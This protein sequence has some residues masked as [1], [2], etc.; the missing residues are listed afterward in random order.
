MENECITVYAPD[1]LVIALAIEKT[2]KEVTEAVRAAVRYQLG[3]DKASPAEI[4]KL[5]SAIAIDWPSTRSVKSRAMAGSGSYQYEISLQPDMEADPRR[6]IARKVAKELQGKITISAEFHNDRRAG[7]QLRARLRQLVEKKIMDAPGSRPPDATAIDPIVDLIE[8]NNVGSATGHNEAKF[9]YTLQVRPDWEFD[10]PAVQFSDE[11][12]VDREIAGAVVAQWGGEFEAG[13]REVAKASS[14]EQ[15]YRDLDLA[16]VATVKKIAAE[17]SPRIALEREK[18]YKVLSFI[19]SQVGIRKVGSADEVFFKLSLAPARESARSEARTDREILDAAAFLVDRGASLGDGT[20]SSIMKKLESKVKMHFA[21]LLDKDEDVRRVMEL[22]ELYWV[23]G[24]GGFYDIR[25]KSAAHMANWM[26]VN[27]HVWQESSFKGTEDAKKLAERWGREQIQDR[28]GPSYRNVAISTILSEITVKAGEPTSI[29]RVPNSTE[30]LYTIPLSFSVKTEQ[31]EAVKREP[32]KKEKALATEIAMLESKRAAFQHL[33]DKGVGEP[34]KSTLLAQ[35]PVLEKTILEKTEELKALQARPEGPRITLAG[36]L[37][38]TASSRSEARTDREILDLAID[39][40]SRGY[41][42]EDANQLE[43]L[44][45]FVMNAELARSEGVPEPEVGRPTPE[46]DHDI[47]RVMEL[48]EIYKIKDTKD[49]YLRLTMAARLA[50]FMN[51]NHSSWGRVFENEE[52]RDSR[53]EAAAQREAEAFGRAKLM[54][55]S[56]GV[57]ESTRAR[58]TVTAGDM[59]PSD[60]VVFYCQL[61]YAVKPG[62]AEAV[63]ASADEDTL[64]A[65]IAGLESKRAAFQKMLDKKGIVDSVRRTL[66]SQIPVLEEAIRTKKEALAALQAQAKK[67]GKSYRQIAEKVVNALPGQTI[68]VTYI[69]QPSAVSPA[70]AHKVALESLELQV[71]AELNKGN[72]DTPVRLKPE[73]MAKYM[74][75]IHVPSNPLKARRE[76]DGSSLFE[77]QVMLAPAA[78]RSEARTDGEKLISRVDLSHPWLRGSTAEVRVTLA[79]VFQRS[80]IR[81][82]VRGEVAPENIPAIEG[83]ARSVGNLYSVPGV[84]IFMD[85]AKRSEARLWVAAALMMEQNPLPEAKIQAGWKALKAPQGI[86]NADVL[87]MGRKLFLADER[88][89]VAVSR[90]SGGATIAV[91]VKGREE[92]RLLKELNERLVAAGLK[93]ILAADMLRKRLPTLGSSRVM[94]LLYQGETLPEELSQLIADENVIRVDKAM[95]GKFLREVGDFVKDLVSDLAGRFA[96]ARSA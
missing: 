51:K 27:S 92:R 52:R 62:R 28:F 55:L 19:R 85:P 86:E 35:I 61:S 17:R 66:V 12:R 77:F 15:A 16:L 32:G 18:I 63:K 4:D 54:E 13:T 91:V 75:W 11:I 49:Y 9:H 79:K 64:A 40:S 89:A 5:M 20:E 25:L 50:D 30:Y 94:A 81:D 88:A 24:G 26:N 84:G 80:E 7:D 3:G 2:R 74:S 70:E 21:L 6:T 58:I 33:L 39:F 14:L 41:S 53:W 48:L 8:A 65:E 56:S 90:S 38:E 76:T 31:S 43:E 68:T 73:E 23:A 93:P 67:I 71:I 82:L 10:L 60:D 47:H 34:V 78:N 83:A 57:D 69:P 29:V 72:P 87:L 22:L 59:H 95:L 1:D 42:R 44:T 36:S 45:K 96:T 46:R 37:L